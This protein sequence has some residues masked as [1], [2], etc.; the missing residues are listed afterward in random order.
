MCEYREK[1]TYK[2]VESD[3]ALMFVQLNYTLDRGVPEHV[4]HLPIL[5]LF[6]VQRKWKGGTEISHIHPA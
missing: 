5:G 4:S 1:A 3:R 2:I 6:E